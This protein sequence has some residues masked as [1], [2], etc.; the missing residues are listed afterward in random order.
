MSVAPAVGLDRETLDFTLEAI[1]EFAARHLPDER[2]LELDHHDECPVDT[3]RLMC[4]EELGIQ[5]VF[6]PEE[7]GGMGGGAFDVYRVCEAHG[8]HRPRRGDR[9]ARDVPRH[10]PDHG[11]RHRG[12]EGAA[13][14]ARSPRRARSIAYG[15][16]EP[17][18]GSDLGALRTTATPIEDGDVVTGYRITGAQ[19]VDQQRRRRRRLHDPRQRP[20]RPDLVR[21]RA[22][23]GRASRHGKPEDKH[24][25]RLSQ[26]R[27]ARRST[28]SRSAP[29]PSW[30]R[31]RARGC[32]RPS[33]SSATRASWWRPSASAPAGRPSTARSRTPRTRIQAGGA[34]LARSRATPTS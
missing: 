21:R 22:G 6:I 5:L 34:A 4:G 24:G 7:Y 31:S 23:R 14:S 1:R 9:R 13:G 16:T 18:A 28:T 26:H 8:R 12:A 20:R 11:R 32:C 25:I 27:G 10:R 2:L 15:A 19:A 29:T 3:V 30:A 17:E 33:R